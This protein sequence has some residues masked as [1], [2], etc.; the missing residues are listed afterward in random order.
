MTIR[1]AQDTLVQA[2]ARRHAHCWVCNPSNGRGLAVE[3]IQTSAGVVEGC[4]A[5]DEAYAGYRGYLHGGVVSSLLDGAMT[6]CL[7]ARG[8][9]AVTA[10]LRV[11]FRLPVATGR[12]AMVRA[13]LDRS[14]RQVHI[15]GAELRQG[16]EVHAT[17]VGK[18]MRHPQGE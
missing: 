5:C 11:R 14:R 7:L 6:N 15:L 12:P 1:D 4:F 8:C 13:W 9:V 10:E 16:G 3:F 17:A 2:R 18:F